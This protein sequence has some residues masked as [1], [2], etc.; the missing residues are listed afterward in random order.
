MGCAGVESRSPPIEKF[1]EEYR[2][3]RKRVRICRR[4]PLCFSL[5]AK[6]AHEFDPV[7]R[8]R[9]GDGGDQ[10]SLVVPSSVTIAPQESKRRESNSIKKCALALSFLFF[11]E[12]FLGRR[13]PLSS[14]A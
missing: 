5:H 9:R 6:R 7:A 1:A 12:P 10:L 4:L 11:L 8:L 14:K 2:S 13:K 3:E